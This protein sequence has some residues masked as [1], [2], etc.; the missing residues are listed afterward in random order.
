MCEKRGSLGTTSA[1]FMVKLFVHCEK[2]SLQAGGQE[3]RELNAREI[4]RW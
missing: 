3:K 4:Q 2:E 1:V